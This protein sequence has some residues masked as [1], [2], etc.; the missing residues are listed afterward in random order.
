MKHVRRRNIDFEKVWDVESATGGR[1]V[2][3]SQQERDKQAADSTQP[4]ST[5]A[6]ERMLKR[7]DALGHSDPEHYVWCASQH[8]KRSEEAR[9]QVGRRWRSYGK[10]LDY[11]DSGFT[12]CVTLSSQG[13]WR[14]ANPTTSSKP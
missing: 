14:P 11:L 7:A 3:H 9:E 13:S 6:V 8:H 12:I 2:Y 4:G 10:Q 1:P 5:R